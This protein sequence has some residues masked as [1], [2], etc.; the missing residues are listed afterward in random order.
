MLHDTKIRLG[1]DCWFNVEKFNKNSPVWNSGW[2]HNLILN[3]GLDALFDSNLEDIMTD[4][5]IGTGSSEPSPTQSGLDNSFLTESLGGSWEK[6]SDNPIIYEYT[7]NVTFST[8]NFSGNNITELGIHGSAFLNRQLLRQITSVSDESITTGDGST[9]AFT[10]SSSSPVEPE[11]ISITDGTQTIYDDGYGNLTGDVDS[12]GSNI[13][14]YDNGDYEFTFASAPSDGASI[15]ISYDWWDTTSVTVLSDEGLRVYIKF[16]YYAWFGKDSSYTYSGSFEYDDQVSGTTP[17]IG[18]TASL[19][20]L[21]NLMPNGLGSFDGSFTNFEAYDL[22]GSK[23]GDIW[24][25]ESSTTSAADT[26][27]GDAEVEVTYEWSA[28]SYEGQ[29]NKLRFENS[30]ASPPEKIDFDLDTDLQKNEEDK[31][32]VT[33]ILSWGRYYGTA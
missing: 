9:K 4:L 19:Y 8:G 1:F 31:I 27:S 5:S 23:V 30:N 14:D 3:S 10:H 29:F 22:S 6:I 28:P 17:T 18:Y 25:K 2:F 12:V 13:V 11:T 32:E 20:R 16:R 24:Y 33:A 15:T 26:T 21:G 7:A